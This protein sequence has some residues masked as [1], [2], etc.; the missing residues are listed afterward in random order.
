MAKKEPKTLKGIQRKLATGD[1]RKKSPA[2][3]FVEEAFGIKEKQVKK[4]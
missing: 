1:G 3:K 4:K 2:E